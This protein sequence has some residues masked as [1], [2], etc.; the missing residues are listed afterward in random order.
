MKRMMVVLLISALVI[1]LAAGLSL[2]QELTADQILDKMDEVSDQV[3]AGS[4]IAKVRFDI[5]HAD[6]TTTSKVFG[7][8]ARPGKSLICFLAPED[9]AGSIFLTVEDEDGTKRMWIYLPLLGTPKELVSEEERSGS[10]AGSSLSYEDIG[11]Q[12][13]RDDYDA[14]LTGTEE[15][16]IG[17]LTRTAYVLESTAKPD[18]DVDE[19]RTVMWV[20]SEYFILLKIEGY[21]D[22]GNLNTT[23]EV[24]SLTEFEGRLVADVIVS[25][26]LGAGITTTITFLGRWRPDEEIPDDVFDPAN[27]PSF[28]P[29][30]WGLTVED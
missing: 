14:T 18:A 12:D 2:A 25:Q 5:S 17:D 22:L 10:F 9:E 29:S 20:D 15:L 19:I 1:L 28:V 6:G 7:T 27:L 8:L 3:N 23:M 4:L 16:T 24:T 11:S 26:D 13:R 30:A 21:N